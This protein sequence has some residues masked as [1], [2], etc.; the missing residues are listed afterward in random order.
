M[1]DK[2]TSYE[3]RQRAQDN[4]G[5]YRDVAK[6]LAAKQRGA[7]R[8]SVNEHAHVQTSADDDGAF[9]EVQLWI[10]KRAIESSR[11]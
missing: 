9:V 1:A 5:A 10:P 11:G 2:S 3:S 6:R 8:M 7:V 4:R